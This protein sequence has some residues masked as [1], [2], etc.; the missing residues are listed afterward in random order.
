METGYGNV[1]KI[2]IDLKSSPLSTTLEESRYAFNNFVIFCHFH[3][4]IRTIPQTKWDC[5]GEH[6]THC[7]PMCL[8]KDYK[9]PDD[10]QCPM[11]H[12]RV[13]KH[14]SMGNS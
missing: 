1:A 10:D 7:C 9:K 11:C 4:S 13:F 5:E 12:G 14:P 6:G 3:N 8:S 2:I